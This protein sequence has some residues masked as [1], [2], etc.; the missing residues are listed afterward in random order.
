MKLLL[1][2]C[3]WQGNGARKLSHSRWSK[4]IGCLSDPNRFFIV[5]QNTVL[6]DSRYKC[7]WRISSLQNENLLTPNVIQDV[8]VFLSSVKKKFTFLKLGF[9]RKTFQDFS[10]YSGL[11]WGTTLWLRLILLICRNHVNS[12]L[13]LQPV[14]RCTPLKSNFSS[15]WT[16]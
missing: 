5:Y 13:K 14:N 4:V 10:P 16:K 2:R 15:T 9:L 7:L 6:P 3:F 8:H 12:A 1:I 11:Q